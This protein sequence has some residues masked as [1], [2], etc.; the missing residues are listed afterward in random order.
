MSKNDRNPVNPFTGK[1]HYDKVND[2][3]FLAE[4]YQVYKQEISK[5]QL[6]DQTQIG[7]QVSNISRNII[8]AVEDYLKKIGRYDYV[9]GY[10]DWEVHLV[11]SNI[12]NACCYPG[13]K[14]IVYAG[15]IQMMK[16]EDELAFVLG[17][18][19]SHALLDHSRT[20]QSIHQ[21]KNTVSTVSWIGSY[22]LDMIGLGGVGNMAR[23]AINVADAG[24]QFF[25]TQPWGRD[26]ELEADKLGLIFSYLAGYNVNIV[27]EFWKRFSQSSGNDFD[28][29]ST[30]P[31]DDKRIAVM[32]ESLHEISQNPD[33]YSKPV[34]PE[35][36]KAKKEF[37]GNSNTPTP[38]VAPNN[39]N[40]F[41]CPKCGNIIKACDNFCNNCG[42]NKNSRNCPKCGHNNKEG[43]NFCTECGNKL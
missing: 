5:Y 43:E 20:Q 30:H 27:P 29:F 9:E 8:R 21:T 38:S 15:I 4:C 40:Q 26:H 32:K 3:Q 35:T 31:S 1:K 6:L 13:G 33:F 37:S 41:N 24:S 34:L 10:Y 36:P 11:N 25:L 18:E 17:H 39:Q 23:A 2:D 7:Q 19:I 16:S 22:A 12:V 42:Y 14:I 28:F